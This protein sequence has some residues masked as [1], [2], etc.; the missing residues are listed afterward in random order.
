MHKC[1]YVHV[2]CFL[3]AIECIPLTILIDVCQCCRL[4][5]CLCAYPL[6]RHFPSCKTWWIKNLN[7]N[8]V[9]LQHYKDSD[10]FSA[11]WVV[12]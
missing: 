6:S 3:G 11:C 10:T 4:L 12:N 5:K 2:C 8:S 7:L 1:M 9:Q